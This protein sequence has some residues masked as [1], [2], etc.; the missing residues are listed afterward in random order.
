MCGRDAVQISGDGA[1]L[2]LEQLGRRLRGLGEV[3]LNAYVLRFLA[4][5]REMT[6]FADGRAIIK[7]VDDIAAARSFYARYV[8]R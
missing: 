8:G 3:R 5:P 1:T 4:P 2:D 6:V 7:G